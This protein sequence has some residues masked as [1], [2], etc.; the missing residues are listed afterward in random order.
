M[1]E[2]WDWD[3]ILLDC[4]L[5]L[6]TR[7]LKIGVATYS[8]FCFAIFRYCNQINRKLIP[9][10]HAFCMSWMKKWWANIHMGDLTMDFICSLSNDSEKGRCSP[11]YRESSI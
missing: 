3:F 4:N 7:T 2:D 11:E 1:F 5:K 10:S 8:K 6:P 9:N